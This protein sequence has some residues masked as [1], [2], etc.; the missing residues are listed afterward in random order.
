M[1]PRKKADEKSAQLAAAAV[2]AGT[3]PVSAQAEP[4]KDGVL[5]DPDAEA[6]RLE[7]EQ[8]AAEEARL[9]AEAQAAEAARLEA[10][11]QATKKPVT[12]QEINQLATDI[13]LKALGLDPV[14]QQ[15]A[16]AD[17]LLGQFDVKAKS[18]AG[19]W[20]C[21]VQ[22]LH[23]SPTRVFVVSD[24]ADVPHD[25]DCEI[26]C[27]YLTAEEAKRVYGDPWLKVLIDSEVIKD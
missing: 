27:C 9:A 5:V 14:Q 25:H 12:E 1:A 16:N 18:P 4:K 11:Q 8:Q 3:E 15:Q 23:S 19:F 10:E 22:F 21:R 6:A 17:W 26:P 7:A 2:G 24:K 20:R 13:T